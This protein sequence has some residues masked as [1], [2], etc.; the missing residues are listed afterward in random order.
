[1]LPVGLRAMGATYD[2]D[3]SLALDDL[4]WH[5]GNWHHKGLAR[6]TEIGLVEIGASEMATIFGNAFS[7]AILFW[8]ELGQE[9]WSSWY[10]NSPLEFELEALN[11]RAWEILEEKEMGLFSYW[12]EYARNHPERIV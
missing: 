9:C 7:K 3:V 6:E 11:K 8:E 10:P 5:F 2:L 12:V 1:M 4:G